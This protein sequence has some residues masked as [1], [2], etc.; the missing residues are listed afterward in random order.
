VFLGASLIVSIANILFIIF[1]PNK[2]VPVL[3]S[4][5]LEPFALTSILI[6]SYF[7][8]TRTRSS[9]TLL[10]IF[11]PLYITAIAIWART[12][13]SRD[14]DHFLVILSL[15]CAALSLAAIAFGFECKGPES[16][17]F[18]SD[19]YESPILT[20]NVYSIWVT[21]QFQLIIIRMG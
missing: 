21:I 19:N 14:L 18:G 1:H 9:S 2:P 6:F 16:E 5:L 12:V 11:W 20:A 10:L 8:H 3:Q 7:N 17:A 4:Y 15:K 13:M